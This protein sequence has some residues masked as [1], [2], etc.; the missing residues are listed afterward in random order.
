MN[1]KI[2]IKKNLWTLMGGDILKE[3]S[4][5]CVSPNSPQKVSNRLV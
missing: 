5:A 2:L 3:L 4:S 1:H